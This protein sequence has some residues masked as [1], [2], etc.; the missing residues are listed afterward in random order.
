MAC[1][2]CSKVD[3]QVDANY[4]LKLKLSTTTVASSQACNKEKRINLTENDVP[5]ASVQ[6]KETELFHNDQLRRWLKC[7]GASTSGNRSQL[8]Q[9]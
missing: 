3:D 4:A 6:D 5:G 2:S 9:R 1:V 8:P 7:R